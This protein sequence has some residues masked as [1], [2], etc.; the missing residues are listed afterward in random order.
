M[1]SVSSLYVE[2]AVLYG[3]RLK[4]EG[5]MQG[6]CHHSQ[7]AIIRMCRLEESRQCPQAGG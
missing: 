7:N 6:S 3:S 4:Y 5:F 1:Y 2:G